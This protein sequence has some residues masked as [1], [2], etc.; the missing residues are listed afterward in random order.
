ME[1]TLHV[2][3]IRLVQIHVKIGQKLACRLLWRVQLLDLV[4]SLLVKKNL[5]VRLEVE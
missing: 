2:H 1:L 4:L 3:L 5:M